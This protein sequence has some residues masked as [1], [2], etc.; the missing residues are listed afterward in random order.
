MNCPPIGVNDFSRFRTSCSTFLHTAFSVDC[1]IFCFLVSLVST[2]E[3]V[4]IGMGA[5]LH[6]VLV[7]FSFIYF[8]LYFVYVHT[9]IDKQFDTKARAVSKDILAGLVL[10]NCDEKD[11]VFS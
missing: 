6:F 3:V 11:T 5:K 9:K 1:E 4:K 2:L 7:F 10:G 8:L